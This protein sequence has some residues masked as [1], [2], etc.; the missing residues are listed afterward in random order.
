VEAAAADPTAPFFMVESGRSAGSFDGVTL[1]LANS[2]LRALFR[3][4]AAPLLDGVLLAAGLGLKQRR[5]VGRAASDVGRRL[6]C[7]PARGAHRGA[8][9]RREGRGTQHASGTARNGQKRPV[10]A[11]H[12]G[13]RVR[14]GMTVM[15]PCNRLPRAHWR[16]RWTPT[17][18]CWRRCRRGSG[19]WSCLSCACSH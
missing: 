2:A 8:G 18:S 9:E 5:W 13:A 7:R 16:P 1:E 3:G 10:T 4:G 15:C 11:R 14:L 12:D 19:R 6:A 17:P